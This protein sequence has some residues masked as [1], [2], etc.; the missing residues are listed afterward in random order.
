MFRPLEQRGLGSANDSLDNYINY[1][2]YAIHNGYGA[3]GVKTIAT[4]AT[5]AL[6]YIELDTHDLFGMMEGKATHRA[7]TQVRPGQRPFIIG[8]STF[9]SSGKWTG[10]WV[11]ETV[12][13]LYL[14][15]E[16]KSLYS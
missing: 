11:S 4:N 2:P 8:R 9:P 5:H 16:T 6:G 3:L 7:L 1:P 10:H 15:V 14:S 13:V 12:T